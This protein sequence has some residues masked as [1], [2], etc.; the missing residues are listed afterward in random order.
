MNI[1]Q[2][3]NQINAA[4]KDKTAPEDTTNLKYCEQ[5]TLKLYYQIINATI[6]SVLSNA[7]K[8]GAK[9]ITENYF[10]ATN[11]PSKERLNCLK[12]PDC[13][14]EQSEYESK[15]LCATFPKLYRVMN[16]NTLGTTDEIFSL[17]L[18]IALLDKHP[19]S[20]LFSKIEKDTED[21]CDLSFYF[22]STLENIKAFNTMLATEKKQ[23]K[24]NEQEIIEAFKVAQNESSYK[25]LIKSIRSTFKTNKPR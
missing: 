1:T 21:I 18:F 9:Y 25:R 23:A 14:I 13:Q 8:Y 15:I 22:T 12:C 20:V 16:Y 3:I 4:D 24:I 10:F 6:D 19:Y 11:R 5:S 2:L 17:D 7:R